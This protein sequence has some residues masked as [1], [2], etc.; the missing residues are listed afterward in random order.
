MTNVQE[1]ERLEELLERT[2]M[3]LLDLSRRN[4]LL[5]FKEVTRDVALIDVEPDRLL[6]D[7]D[8]G[9]S[10]GFE[11]EEILDEDLFS[12]PG[13]ARSAP[14][15]RLQ[16]EYADRD[17]LRRLEKLQR[18]YRTLLEETGGNT[19]FVAVGFLTF[20]D[21]TDSQVMQRAPLIL[22]PVRMVKDR[23]RAI[24]SFSIARHD[25]E[26]DTNF[27][28]LHKLDELGFRLPLIESATDEEESEGARIV[29]S[30]YLDL[31]REALIE[32]RDASWEVEEDVVLGLFRFQKQVMWHDLD[33]GRW[34]AHAP[35]TDSEM[36]QRVLLGAKEGERA[37]GIL[38]DVVDQEA[39]GAPDLKLIL[40]ADS[41][42]FSALVDALG[43]DSGLV[44]EGPPGT[45]KSQTISNLVAA[46]MH[47]GLT[48]L[49]VAEK[50]AALEV[51]Y[52]R[53]EGAGLQDLCLQL[54]GLSTN[55]A[56]LAQNLKRRLDLQAPSRTA[57]QA[58]Q[59]KWRQ[60]RERLKQTSRLLQEPLGP[61]ALPAHDT[62][63]RLEHGRG[64]LP[65]EFE[66]EALEIASDLTR[67]EFEL[68]KDRL[69]DLGQGWESVPEGARQVWE[70]FRPRRVTE[71]AQ[72]RI[73][74]VLAEAVAEIDEHRAR[75]SREGPGAVLGED[76]PL[77]FFG[78]LASAA[79]SG[80]L[81]TIAERSR[82]ATIY[83]L[84]ASGDLEGGRRLLDRLR[85]YL[86]SAGACAE[87]FDYAA[88][89]APRLVK[90]IDNHLSPVVGVIDE[91][92]MTVADLTGRAEQLD[93]AL[94][95]LDSLPAET[96]TVCE[97]L[98][99]RP[100]TLAEFTSVA[101]R[102]TELVD[103]P[104]ELVL[105]GDARFAKSAAASWLKLGRERAETLSQQLAALNEFVPA[106]VSDPTEIATDLETLRLYAD[107][108]FP[109]LRKE[110]RQARGR[111]RTLCA[112]SAS[113]SRSSEFMDRLE[114]LVRRTDERD[115]LKADAELQSF[116]GP[117]FKGLETDWSVL[118]AF[119]TTGE[120][121][122]SALGADRAGQVLDDWAEQREIVQRTGEAVGAVVEQCE[123]LRSTSSIPAASWRRPARE[124][125]EMLRPHARRLHEAAAALAT[126]GVYASAAVSDSLIAA[127]EH[128]PAAE[129]LESAVRRDPLFGG[130]LSPS[131]C[132]A[133]T[134]PQEL[135]ASIKWVEG[136][137]A[138]PWCSV[139][140]LQWLIPDARGPAQARID[141]VAQVASGIVAVSA[142]V[143]ETLSHIGELQHELWGASA[144]EGLAAYSEHLTRCVQY[145]TYLLS[146]QQ[147]HG[148]AAEVSASGLDALVDQLRQGALDGG[149]V[150]VAFDV[151]VHRDAFASFAEAHE[152]LRGFTHS[153][154][155]NLR[156]RFAEVDRR[157]LE[158]AGQE[159]RRQA[160]KR[161]APAGRSS[162]KV[163]ELTEMGLINH[164]LRLQR[165]HRPIRHLVDKAGTSLQALK[166]C[167]LMSPM[168]VAQ[169][170]P[171]GGMKFDLLVMDEA[172]QIRPEEA[173]GAIARA[174]K[175]IVVGDP[176]QLPPT[177]FFDSSSESAGDGE[178]EFVTENVESILDVC[179]AQVPYRRL[180]WHYRSEHEALIQFSNE[181]FY[182]ND[183]H[184]FPS[185]RREVRDL[186]V[187]ATFVEEPSYRRGGHNRGEATVVV[188]KIV[189]TL[190]RFP[191][192][193][194]G[195]VAMNKRQA[196]DIEAL[197][198]RARRDRPELD[199]LITELAEPIFV[200]NLENVQGDERD[201]IVIS[202]TY[203]PEKAGGPV[204][205][206]FGP[207][208]SDA[209][210]RR[211]N[212]IATRARQRVE[213]VTSLRPTDVLLGENPKRGLR[214]FRNYLE[215]A[216][217]GRV[218]ELGES[219]GQAPD[220]DFERSVLF[221]L[222]RLGFEGEP[223]VGVAGFFIDIGV[224]HPERPGEFLLGIEC[225]GATY[226]SA[227][228]VRDRD[229]LRQE[230]LEGKGWRI[231]RIW[232]TSWFHARGAELERL[233]LTIADA[234]EAGRRR[235]RP[236]D[237]STEDSAGAVGLLSESSGNDDG[238]QA[239]GLA[240]QPLPISD[241]KPVD[242]VER[243]KDDAL[244]GEDS[245]K[246]L[247]EE[248]ERYWRANIQEQFPD[249][250]RSI[251]SEEMIRYLVAKRPFT[252]EEFQEFL[253]L[254]LRTTVRA[255]EMEFLLDILGII[256]EGS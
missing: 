191:G 202:T 229:R 228:S 171:R 94:G 220:S 36:L 122:R 206:R 6:R 172:S 61:L 50:M 224:K 195:A 248:L 185:P 49:F 23:G 223:Q 116:L 132:G 193:T 32:N 159:V 64:R 2:R 17:L 74:E 165:R 211:L 175:C 160:L 3:S 140:L 143:V 128:F 100:S 44:I 123:A 249:R 77:E 34:P 35:L 18:E 232:S 98:E 27:S 107:K 92:G 150:P 119:V 43:R 147:W 76:A 227:K 244:S 90:L 1:G 163:G 199:D 105:Y 148:V 30:R 95:A 96:R 54:H 40:D 158:L 205:R 192:S 20:R 91:P 33:P 207:I 78:E 52:Q 118:E 16:T 28:L 112:D 180:T 39:E 250:A 117:L 189:E 141:L 181:R 240:D 55:K 114:E 152:E 109:A 106:R 157:L 130:L 127:R 38:R 65:D 14:G 13:K 233:R 29:P 45:G 8:D 176:K 66:P 196:E 111:V 255:P 15:S 182:E 103:G 48:V 243:A 59:R 209:G 217:S 166:P 179:L 149:Q 144:R 216:F 9:A 80:L 225:D 184:V 137:L 125:A 222:E 124:I 86:R 60:A 69:V 242:P 11:P 89:D 82:V 213:V 200:K 46:A 87:V 188:D 4:R 10:F 226:H 19:L 12:G 169:F 208:N 71:A 236:T 47:E 237:S 115:R 97:L 110:Y 73:G 113:F 252:H 42:Q 93:R 88:T 68:A 247:S 231:H 238:V 221:H 25:D 134:N 186:G 234:L 219:T 62:V 139:R 26:L 5:N 37:P 198:D 194:I 102:A 104:D 230:I 168:S 253:P 145:R 254:E 235:V 167:F 108:W 239:A 251:L 178:E 129:R 161:E 84:V 164:Q 70:G 210:W 203:G 154:Y 7:L 215:Y 51:V 218:P 153:S 57:L 22:I 126:D 183:L 174:T 101:D 177:S 173:L 214:E 99:F 31:V 162:G 155:E 204:A 133:D 212:V 142:R 41:S 241:Q 81:P 197:L 256:E 85:A 146:L 120:R 136:T 151:C 201:V 245:T 67:E 79:S 63:W 53:L 190:A 156:A 21:S 72:R 138:A 75:W 131:W 58:E 135:E 24:D 56:E 121:L 246:V 170:L 187:H 83:A